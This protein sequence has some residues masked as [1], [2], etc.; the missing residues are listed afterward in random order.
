MPWGY[1][2]KMVPGHMEIILVGLNSI[3][4]AHQ[5]VSSEKLLSIFE[6]WFLLCQLGLLIQSLDFCEVAFLKWYLIF[7]PLI[8]VQY[9]PLVLCPLSCFCMIA[10]NHLS[11][12]SSTQG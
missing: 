11:S 7:T 1:K 12:T 6:F 5:L 8:G 2:V 9:F 10:Y 4:I 3:S